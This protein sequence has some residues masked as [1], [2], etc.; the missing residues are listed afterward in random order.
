MLIDLGLHLENYEVEKVTDELFLGQGGMATIAIDYKQSRKV[1]ESTWAINSLD[2]V[3]GVIGGLSGIVWTVLS[4]LFGGYEAFKYQ[5]S[6]ISAVYPTAPA[7]EPIDGEIASSEGQHM[8]K[9]QMMQKIASRRKYWYSYS[10]YLW[11]SLLATWLCCCVNGQLCAKKRVQRLY[12]HNK[13]AEKL[14]DEIDIVK[15]LYVQR[16]G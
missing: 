10:E 12:R 11:A 16:I 4:M 1:N 2:Q 13:A 3:L 8:A 9:V 5:N 14:A 7:E 15:L 6:L